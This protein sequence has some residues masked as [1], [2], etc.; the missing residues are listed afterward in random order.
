[1]RLHTSLTHQ[2][3]EAALERAKK[4]GRVDPNIYPVDTNS[5]DATSFCNM[6]E[7]GSKT[8]VRSFEIQ[9]G[10]D[11][12]TPIPEPVTR[13]GRTQKTRRRSQ[14]GTWAATWREWGWFMAEV[15]AADPNARWGTAPKY[16]G[17]DERRWGYFDLTDFDQ[18]TKYEFCLD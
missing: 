4:A 7:H 5:P 2:Q 11:I 15:F 8:H 10:S 17:K 18:K 14:N 1:M 13:F 12:Y 3:V 16:D 9:L 6:A